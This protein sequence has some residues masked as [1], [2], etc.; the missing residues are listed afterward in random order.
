[1]A[2]DTIEKNK[3]DSAYGN[4]LK[5]TSLIGASSVISMALSV[6]R[7]K[8]LAVLLGP[9]GVGL[10]GL[11]YV[12]IELC[13]NLASFG[14]QSS[15]VRQVAVAT[16]SG[17]L[18]KVA[19]IAR[20][21]KLS[22]IVLGI[23]GAIL[24]AL[25]AVPISTLTFGTAG[26]ASAVALLGLAVLLRILSGAPTAIIQGNRRIGDLARMT[27]V[28]AVL[29]TVAAIPLV[30]FFGEAGIVPSLLALGLT[31]WIAALWYCRKIHLPKVKLTRPE[32][33]REASALL[34]LGF[35]F[36]ASGFL[37]VGAAFVIRILVVQQSGVDAAG[38]YQA[39]WA[40]GGIYIGFILQ[41]MGTD[42][43]PRLSAISAD[44]VACN[45][46][47]NEQ[48]R[49]SILLA[50]PGLLGTLALAPLVITVFYSAQFAD[51]VPLLRW[52]CLGMLLRVISWPMGFIV[53]AKG[54]QKMFFWTEVAAATVHVGLAWLLLGT[55]G[56]AGAG[57]AFVGLYVWHAILIYVL[58][59]RMSGFRWTRDNLILGTLFLGLTISVLLVVEL[60][61]FWPGLAIAIAG[62]LLGCWISATQL[63]G[64]VPQKWIPSQLRP[65]IYFLLRH[66]PKLVP[67]RA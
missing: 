61:P 5:S 13:A 15:G 25:L 57:I 24:V 41:A 6:V 49:V 50:G 38:N 31:S 47:V 14:I 34:K 9:A 52:F 51:A 42:F 22:S 56:L 8:V 48:A 63:I 1:M 66:Q 20:V 37:T 7:L 44:N 21:L 29:N 43:F 54:A 62:T 35:A 12:V 17:D 27:V 64:L 3:A 39:A 11:Y 53:L 58:V 55:F 65:L 40:L 30:Y 36:M 45:R 18:V 26:R 59:R 28:G 33:S 10:F 19:K 23:V 60:A 67:E 46:S 4:I 2:D 32:F 16:S